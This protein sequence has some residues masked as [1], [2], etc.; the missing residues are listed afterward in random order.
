[1]AL[2]TC[3]QLRLAAWERSHPYSMFTTPLDCSTTLLP[4]AAKGFLRTAAS[5][6]T[7]AGSLIALAPQAHVNDLETI[8]G[9]GVGAAAGTI[10]GQSVGGRNSAVIGG[11]VGGAVSTRGEGQN[12]AGVGGPT[13]AT[14]GRNV[15]RDNYYQQA[16]YRPERGYRERDDYRDYERNDWREEHHGNHDDDHNNDRN[17]DFCLGALNL[18]AH[19]FDQFRDQPL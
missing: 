6:L 16:D 8:L 13:G 1:M 9:G 4:H 19:G 18:A 17:E 12:G 11:A 15:G 2:Q 5:G 7:L 10:L 14:I 3:K